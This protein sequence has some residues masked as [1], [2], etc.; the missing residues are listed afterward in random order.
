ML[1]QIKEMADAAI[2][3]QN[4]LNMEATLKAISEMCQIQPAEGYSFVNA[5][6]TDKNHWEVAMIPKLDAATCKHVSYGMALGGSHNAAQVAGDDESIMRAAREMGNAICEQAW[7]RQKLTEDQR[8]QEIDKMAQELRI[9]APIEALD[10]EF[11]QEARKIREN[12]NGHA[13]VENAEKIAANILQKHFGGPIEAG[14]VLVGADGKEFKIDE[15]VG[16]GLAHPKKEGCAL[17]PD[18]VDADMTEAQY[19]KQ[20]AAHLRDTKPAKK[21]AKK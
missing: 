21:G 7:N 9:D 15:V 17:H 20:L 18:D 10:A 13:S 2:K 12:Y 5:R 4:K 14:D 3:L 8:C 1:N 16:F 6:F 19:A 11:L